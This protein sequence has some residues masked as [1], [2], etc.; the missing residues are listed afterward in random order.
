MSFVDKMVIFF[1]E[2]YESLINNV[3]KI[4]DSVFI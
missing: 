2:W 4:F 3:L 1:Y